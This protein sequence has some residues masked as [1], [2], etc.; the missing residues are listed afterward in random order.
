MN[1]KAILLI[2]GFAVLIGSLFVDTRFAPFI[3]AGLLLAAIIYGWAANR[4]ASA[5]NLRKAERAT[6]RQ[7]KEHYHDERP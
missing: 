6:H 7:R 5:E 4:S 2:I 1:I 3:G